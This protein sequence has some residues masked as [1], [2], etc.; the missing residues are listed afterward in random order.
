[1]TA[2]PLP[3]LSVG[4]FAPNFVAATRGNPKFNF[5]TIP[6][7]Y[8]LLAFLPR[9]AERRAAALA[10]FEPHRPR[11]DDRNATAFFVATDPETCASAQDRTP[12]Q[13]W[14]FDPDGAVSRLYGAWDE[15]GG[16]HP[17]WLLLDPV[18]RVLDRAPIE[19]PGPLF[20]RLYAL[21]APHLHAGVPVVAPC[22]IVPRVF[23]PELCRELIAYYDARGGERSGVMRDIGGKTVGV[24]DNMKSRRD[25]SVSEPEFRRLLVSRLE[26]ALLPAIKRAYQFSATRIERYLIACYDAAEGGFF[27]PHRDNETLGTAHRRFA[28]S[29]NLNAEEFE[30]GDLRFPEFG[31]RTYRPPT[32]GAVVFCCAMQHEATPVT[33]GRRY[34][35]LPFLFDEEGERIRQANESFLAKGPALVLDR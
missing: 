6:G 34:A 19:A 5:N 21:P 8:V 32:G 23:E 13:R 9:D 28:V 31:R 18:L 2:W 4:D 27:M 7:R 3:P 29:I 26:R 12:G 24:L 25:V 33:Q 35:F 14:F 22:L 10:A 11:F 17:F 16:E 1:M 30:G 20:A 15:A